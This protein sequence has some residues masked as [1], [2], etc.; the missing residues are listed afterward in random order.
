MWINVNVLQIY[1][2]P[3]VCAKKNAAMKII[4]FYIKFR[5]VR[6]EIIP[7]VHIMRGL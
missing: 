5:T 6:I 3:L 7:I 1:G 4:E 2:T